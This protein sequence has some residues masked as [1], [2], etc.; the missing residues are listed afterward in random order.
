MPKTAKLQRR[1]SL[2]LLTFYGLGSIL[3]AGI[4]ALVGKVAGEAGLFTPVAFLVGAVLVG[5]TGFAYAE[6]SARFPRAGG[7]AVYA[8]K[9]FG[10]RALTVFIGIL[11]VLAATVSAAAL[12]NA[13]VGYL[14]VFIDA[15]RSV[16]IF[17]TV[18]VAACVVSWGIKESALAT[19]VMTLIEIAGLIIIVWVGRESLMEFPARVP[20]LI[21]P[22][23]GDIWKGILVG[24]FI[25][26]YA[27]IG[28]EDMANVAGEVKDPQR[29]MPRGIILAI[30]SSTVLYMLVAVVAVLALAPA[31]LAGTE[32]PF[33]LLYERNT[34][35][36]P[37]LITF[38]SLFA[39]VNGL[40][41]Q[42]IMGSRMLYGLSSNRW[43]PSFLDTVNPFTH[44]PIRATLFITIVVLCFAL[45]LPLVKLA[46]ITS[47]FILVIFATVNLACVRMKMINPHPK[48]VRTYPMVIPL[49]GFVVIV[50]FIG[51]RVWMLFVG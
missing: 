38:I 19:A 49:I 5:F 41:V 30:V 4:Y 45:W 3:G 29:T 36:A 21:P 26:F 35:S 23:H 8:Q 2:P 42:L 1:L 47:F 14:Q 12:S 15:P 31:E 13:F 18:I 17:I 32:A 11:A 51:F 16:T 20:E 40:L 33:S 48:G 22:L 34:G 39:I 7:E 46:Q 50:S 25:A 6:L 37:T 24:A 28:I 10:V 27:F 43:I 9:A 44:T